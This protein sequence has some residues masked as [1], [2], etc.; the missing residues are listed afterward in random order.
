MTLECSIIKHAFGETGSLSVDFILFL[1][2]A[3]FD[4]FTV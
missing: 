3:C 1:N 4:Y 2:N